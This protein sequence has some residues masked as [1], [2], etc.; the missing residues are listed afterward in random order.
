MNTFRTIVLILASISFI[1]VIGGAV[2][3][4]VGL[5]PVWASA[6]PASLTMFQGEYAIRPFRFWMPI[7]PIT[8]V[9]LLLALAFNWK[10]ERRNF[11]LT[12]IVGYAIVLAVTFLYFVPELM[13]IIQS[14]YATTTDPELTQR[15]QSWEFR[16]QIR[17][18]SMLIMAF[19]L[20]FGL[21]K[22]SETLR[23]RY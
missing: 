21:S 3:E 11:I 22:P 9:L 14:V 2:Y 7:H 12:T 5:V 18:G 4:H 8:V 17:L 15:A 23:R 1:I 6:A 10:T 19:I 16:S 13:S 20:L